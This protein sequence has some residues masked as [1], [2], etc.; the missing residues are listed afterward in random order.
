MSDRYKEFLIDLIAKS[1][2]IIFAVMIIAPIATRSFDI[3]LLISGSVIAIILILWGGSI[4]A[5]MEE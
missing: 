3:P 5:K 1:F 4:S 2:Q